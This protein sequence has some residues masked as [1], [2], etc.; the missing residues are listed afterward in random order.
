MIEL[1]IYLGGLSCGLLAGLWG[2]HHLP[3]RWRA[4]TASEPRKEPP[5][6]FDPIALGLWRGT[7]IRGADGAIYAPALPSSIPEAPPPVDVETM[8]P[9]HWKRQTS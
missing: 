8:D 5:W 6:T 3:A 2:A 7:V 9:V 4:S 1:L